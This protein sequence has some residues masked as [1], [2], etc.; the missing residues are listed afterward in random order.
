VVAKTGRTPEQARAEFAQPATRRAGIVQ[1]ERG[2]DAVRWLLGE[3]AAAVTGQCI[4]V[5]GGEVM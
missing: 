4:S 1:P 3:G 5:C 2:G